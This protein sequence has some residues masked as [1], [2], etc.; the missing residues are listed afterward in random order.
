MPRNAEF[1]ARFFLQ[2]SYV[3][4]EQWNL[5]TLDIANERSLVVLQVREWKWQK[6]YLWKNI[7]SWKSYILFDEN[8]AELSFCTNNIFVILTREP[9]V[10]LMAFICNIKCYQIMFFWREIGILQKKVVIL[11]SPKATKSCPLTQVMPSSKT[12]VLVLMMSLCC[13]EW[14][15]QSY[16]YGI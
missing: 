2:N 7:C 3:S 15:W 6:Y 12:W 8:R 14:Y 9:V 10:Q 11:K 1:M 5:V 13:P 4:P 16:H